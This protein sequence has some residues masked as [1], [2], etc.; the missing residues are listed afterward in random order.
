[1]TC[2]KYKFFITLHR[3][4]AT[5]CRRWETDTNILLQISCVSNVFSNLSLSCWISKQYGI[6]VEYVLE[7]LWSKAYRLQEVLVGLTTFSATN[8]F[9]FS[10]IYL[11]DNFIFFLKIW[12]FQTFWIF[13]FCLSSIFFTYFHFHNSTSFFTLFKTCFYLLVFVISNKLAD[14]ELL[15]LV[16]MN[17]KWSCLSVFLVS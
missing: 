8:C 15:F 1:M 4:P 9:S 14:N 3:I 2:D 16:C 12:N 5:V 17:K 13:N 7:R 6:Y 10:Y 11:K